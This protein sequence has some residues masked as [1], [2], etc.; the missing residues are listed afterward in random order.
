MLCILCIRACALEG[1]LLAE[2]VF[3]VVL[4][5]QDGSRDPQHQAFWLAGTR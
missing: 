3:L 4:A 1:L 5:S 2:L